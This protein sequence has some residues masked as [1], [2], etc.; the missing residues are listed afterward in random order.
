MNSLFRNIKENRNLDALEES[1]DEDEFEDT[2]EDKYVDTTKRINM[3]CEYS[4]KYRSWIPRRIA[5]KGQVPP[6]ISH[7]AGGGNGG[8]GGS[9]NVRSERNR[10]TFRR[11]RTYSPHH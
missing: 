7:L 9:E 10:D 11:S 1:D 5:E 3:V 6:P 2:R 4:A 8:G